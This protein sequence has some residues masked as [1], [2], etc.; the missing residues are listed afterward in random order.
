M[1][2][3]NTKKK[4]IAHQLNHR[5]IEFLNNTNLNDMISPAD[6]IKYFNVSRITATR[7]LKALKELNHIKVIGK[8][9]SIRYIRT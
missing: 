7:D 4:I 2:K 3:I 5:Q 6:Y 8:T 1:P 9:R